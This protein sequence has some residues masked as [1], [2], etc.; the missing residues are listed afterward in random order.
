MTSA[1]VSGSTRATLTE[2]ERMQQ[3]LSRAG[4]AA[5]V[6]KP[7]RM[8]DNSDQFRVLLGSFDNPATLEAARDVLAALGITTTRSTP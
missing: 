2:A 5:Y 3:R 7:A 8:N 4:L 1:P 6:E